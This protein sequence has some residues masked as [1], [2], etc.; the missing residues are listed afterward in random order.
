MVLQNLS[1]KVK[2][3]LL[4]CTLDKWHVQIKRQVVQDILFSGINLYD[5]L[6]NIRQISTQLDTMILA[7]NMQ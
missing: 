5:S 1:K 6:R 4:F 2:F 3:L 7:L